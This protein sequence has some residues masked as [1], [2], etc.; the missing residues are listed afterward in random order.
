MIGLLMLIADTSFST[1]MTG[2]DLTTLCQ[3]NRA[4][5]IHYLEGASDMINGFQSLKA[6]PMAICMDTSVTG[7][8]LMDVTVRFLADHADSLGE[9][10]GRLIWPALYEAFPCAN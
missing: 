2:K 3:T 10:S 6:T 1:F 5:C 7:D 4:A 9:G 8:Q